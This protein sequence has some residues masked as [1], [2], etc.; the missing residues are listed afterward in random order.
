[1]KDDPGNA[2][3]FV[4]HFQFTI[5]GNR[6]PVGPIDWAKVRWLRWKDGAWK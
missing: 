3:R 6:A 4:Q 2:R 5:A 1:M